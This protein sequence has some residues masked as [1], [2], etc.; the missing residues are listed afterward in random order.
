MKNP[1]FIEYRVHYEGDIARIQP[2]RK[3]KGI[4]L[5]LPP[6]TLNISDPAEKRVKDVEEWQAVAAASLEDTKKL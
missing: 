2:V 1:V 5:A 6:F 4:R 3:L